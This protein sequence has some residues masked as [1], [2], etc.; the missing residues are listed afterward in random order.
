MSTLLNRTRPATGRRSL[1]VVLLCMF[2]NMIDGF[3]LFI[4][5]F[6]LPRLPAGFATDGQKGLIISVALVGM[7]VGA[8]GLARYADRFGRRAIVLAGAAINLAGLCLSALAT[9]AELL[10][11][12]RFIT[13][14]GLPVD[15][16]MGM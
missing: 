8:I 1:G 3:D 14:V 5:G 15:G 9:N 12:A 16:G 13:G 7:A 2:L 6:A 4:V 11:G 10:M